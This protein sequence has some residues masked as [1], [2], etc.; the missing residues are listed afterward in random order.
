MRRGPVSLPRADI[1]HVA[2]VPAAGT[3]ERVEANGQKDEEVEASLEDETEQDR[4][5]Q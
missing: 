4:I 1:T 3:A 5:E 2:A